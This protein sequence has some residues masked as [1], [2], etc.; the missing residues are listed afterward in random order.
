[1]K[2][3]PTGHISRAVTSQLK[4]QNPFLQLKATPSN[5]R[6]LLQSGTLVVEES[7]LTRLSPGLSRYH[8]QSHLPC[9]QQH[10]CSLAGQT[11]PGFPPLCPTHRPGGLSGSAGLL[12]DNQFIH[13]K[14]SLAE[15]QLCRSA[16]LFRC[17]SL[18]GG[19]SLPLP[20]QS[21][22]VVRS[23][24]PGSPTDHHQITI[25]IFRFVCGNVAA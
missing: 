1:M 19:T 4:T 10:N 7:C 11:D 22:S 20:L 3:I 18:G 12:Q 17:F 13:F 14:A 15:D 16:N 23:V 9:C 2:Y 5:R 6:G 8:P 21:V 25:M 24:I